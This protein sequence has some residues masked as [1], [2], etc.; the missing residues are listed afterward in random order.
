[1]E[2]SYDLATGRVGCFLWRKPL[3]TVSSQARSP[4]ML[5]VL[6]VFPRRW[7][8]CRAVIWISVTLCACLHSKAAS[9]QPNILLITVDNLGVGDVG[10]YGN[11]EIRTPHL[12]A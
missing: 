7:S 12:D 5:F 1:M 6:L 9:P 11:A 8:A 2:S 3:P 10:C 4:M